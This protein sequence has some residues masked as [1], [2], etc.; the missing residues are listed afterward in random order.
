[1]PEI[2]DCK[3]PVCDGRNPAGRET[4]LYCGQPL[5]D[6]LQPAAPVYARRAG[7]KT[8]GARSP[9]SVLVLE[10]DGKE[11]RAAVVRRGL[12]GFS[13]EHCLKLERLAEDGPV[14]GEEL[15]AV[16]S[17]I[18]RC[19]KNV[20]LVTPLVSMVE[21]SLEAGLVK[22]VRSYQLKEM[23]RW[24]A[25]PYMTIPAGESLVGYQLG[26]ESGDGQ[27]E[28]WVTMLPAE[29]FAAIKKTFADTG[30]RL[31]RVYPPDLCFPVGA[32]LAEKEKKKENV[33][34]VD[35]GFQ[36]MKVALVEERE[37]SSLRTMPT[38]LAAAE[39]G[40]ADLP[41][42]ELESDLARVFEDPTVL[43]CRM[44]L[45]G[46][47]ALDEKIL[48]FFQR[49]T[50]GRASALS[51]RSGG[52]SPEYAAVFG[53]GLRE[54]FFRGGWKTAGIDDSVDPV[55]RFRERVHVFPILAVTVIA[56]F[57]MAHY[58]VLNFQM[59]RAEVQLAVLTQ[60]RDELKG[61]AGRYDSLKKEAEELEQK[62]L[63]TAEKIRFLEAGA[64]NQEVEKV[65]AALLRHGPPDLL[66]AQMVP[67]GADR[68]LVRGISRSA[69]SPSTLA[70]KMQGEE[71]C[72][73]ARVMEVTW[74]EKA[75]KQTTLSVDGLEES[76]VV[77]EAD[78]YGFTMEIA[79]KIEQIAGPGEGDA[80]Y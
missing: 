30:F 80:V 69:V 35:L 59:K 3:C 75:I 65:L 57:F 12:R 28:V 15:E 37:I 26:L 79:K 10:T 29:D 34:V 52:F 21:L 39:V 60:Q 20:V 27:V 11:L 68:W 7:R 44:L 50:Q 17:R 22:K 32:L 46:P 45:T 58:L 49:E 25:E 4:C 62:R 38:G 47:G 74:K 24:E 16:A 73:Y 31:K 2:T 53:A 5:H 63:L 55:R 51:I 76:E 13:L 56:V 41:A 70:L 78:G 40:L 18:T 33:A 8:A 14:T 64:V 36:T 43:S 72:E 48:E 66:F 1:M 71:W 42:S 19:P 6:D 54:L 77:E 61:K 67:A 9:L 23:L